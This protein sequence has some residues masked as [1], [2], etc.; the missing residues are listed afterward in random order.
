MVFLY[1]TASLRTLIKM[2]WRVFADIALIPDDKELKNI[3]ALR[4]RSSASFYLILD[5]Q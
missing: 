3:C 4:F 2:S 1:W 5:V